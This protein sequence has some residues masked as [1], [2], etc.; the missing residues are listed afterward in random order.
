MLLILS[1]IEEGHMTRTPGPPYRPNFGRTDPR[2]LAIV[3][4]AK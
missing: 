3:D 4:H 1:A 2:T